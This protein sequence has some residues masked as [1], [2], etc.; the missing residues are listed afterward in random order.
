ATAYC[1]PAPALPPWSQFE[2]RTAFDVQQDTRAGLT[3]WNITSYDIVYLQEIQTQTY[4][5]S[6]AI[7]I[8]SSCRWFTAKCDTLYRTS[9]IKATPARIQRAGAER[10]FS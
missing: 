8:R 1:C 5:Q 7:V 4:E 6:A 10:D 2:C 9:M 3:I